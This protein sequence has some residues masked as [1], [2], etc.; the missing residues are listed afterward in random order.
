[1]E[2]VKPAWVKK[3]NRRFGRIFDGQFLIALALFA[4]SFRVY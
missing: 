3:V 4:G 2:A 1:M